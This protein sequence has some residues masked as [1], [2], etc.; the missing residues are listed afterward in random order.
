MSTRE[1]QDLFLGACGSE[2]GTMHM[3]LE[4]LKDL[5]QVGRGKEQ[6][7]KEGGGMGKERKV[8]RK[9]GIHSLVLSNSNK[10]STTP[11]LKPGGPKN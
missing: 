9:E 6:E 1:L 8:E 10:T 5:N 7:K 2:K 3:Q 4:E 11:K